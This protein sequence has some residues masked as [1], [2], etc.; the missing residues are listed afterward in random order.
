MQGRSDIPQ[1]RTAVKTLVR[2]E[3]VQYFHE[4][5]EQE[6][7][8]AQ[9]AGHPAA[10]QAHYLLAGYYLDLVHNSPLA[11]ARPLNALQH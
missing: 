3:D 11:P 1:V 5:A 7:L 6:I 4:R 10:V 2:Q 9:A 8:H